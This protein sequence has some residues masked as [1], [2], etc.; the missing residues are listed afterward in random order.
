MKPLRLDPWS[1]RLTN[2]PIT[3]QWTTTFAHRR[4]NVFKNSGVVGFEAFKFMYT[5]T[6]R[7]H[8]NPLTLETFW[9]LQSKTL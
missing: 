1:P 9:P 7:T 4:E 6:H 8:T 3:G 5:H 2:P